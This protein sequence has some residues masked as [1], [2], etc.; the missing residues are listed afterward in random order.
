MVRA[1]WRYFI[2]GNP[3]GRVWH[4]EDQQ[5]FAALNERTLWRD[6][7]LIIAL[8]TTFNILWWLSDPWIFADDPKTLDLMRMGR[9]GLVL[10]AVG[11]LVF[12]SLFPRLVHITGMLAGA[13][14][15]FWVAR[16]MG[17]IGGP[18]TPWF[19][20]LYPF[21]LIQLVIW[22]TPLERVLVTTLFALV[23]L[24]GYFGS[25]P[26]WLL[27]EG[28]PLAL[29]YFTYI[30]ILSY[31]LGLFVDH[32]RL[33]LFQARADLERERLHLEARVAEKTQTL[34]G[35]VTHLDTL[36]DQERSR[37]ARDL[38]DDLGQILVAQRL[39]LDTALRRAR[40]DR[41]PILPNLDQLLSLTNQ[42]TEQ[43]RATL[44]LLRP[45]VL[46]ELGLSAALH[47]LANHANESLQLPCTLT[48][49]PE[50]WEVPD[51]VATAVYRCVQ[52]AVT[53]AAKHAR[54]TRLEIR[55]DL[56]D[57]ELLAEVRDN[58]VGIKLKGTPQGFGLLG[59][60]ER[61]AA[62]GGRL[63]VEALDEGGTRFALR[64]PVN[65]EAQP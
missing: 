48:H 5:A 20:F 23:L 51:G 62:L 58:G 6:I 16:C 25:N 56:C 39:V 34:V 59:A 10:I 54:A 1:I 19:H 14:T 2:T 27:D 45:R 13:L 28:T 43:L 55:I 29:A 37:I 30:I 7:Y 61:V 31:I 3:P 26:D 12:H 52:E 38:H 4:A 21:V 15:V 33:S 42:M 11:I 35:F 53:N 50:L 40:S 24:L 64:I 47:T 17:L 18:S 49:L 9:S 44:R 57:G 8:W 60:S 32:S 46:D 36:Q 41:S 63:E 22:V 65:P